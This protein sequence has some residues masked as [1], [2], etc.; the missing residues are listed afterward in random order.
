TR[1]ARRGRALGQLLLRAAPPRIAPRVL[2]VVESAPHAPVLARAALAA[3]PPR[4]PLPGSARL[5]AAAKSGGARLEPLLVLAPPPPAP[6][7]HRP[8]APRALRA[9][10]PRR[11]SLDRDAG[12]LCGS[13]RALA[14]TLSRDPRLLLRRPVRAARGFRAR[15]LPL[16]RRGPGLR[17]AHRSPP[18][19][20][21]LRAAARRAPP[22]AGAALP[23]PDPAAREDG[24]ARPV[25]LVALASAEGARRA[26]F[27]GG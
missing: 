21:R 2:S 18:E 11:R 10:V 17:A 26:E 1:R 14:R 8:E 6:R 22:H 4:R 27:K 3:R 9:H 5:R 24:R 13:P 25:G 19:R 15:A 12:M 20:A 7:A 23:R 16:R